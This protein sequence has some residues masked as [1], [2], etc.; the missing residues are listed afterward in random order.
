MITNLDML[1][2]PIEHV[3]VQRLKSMETKCI[4]AR[5]PRFGSIIDA[6]KVCSACNLLENRPPFIQSR[7][8]STRPLEVVH[9][10][11]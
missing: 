2:K 10:N 8:V 9:T 3:N 7:N 6:Q 11:V 4:V 1:H 5:L